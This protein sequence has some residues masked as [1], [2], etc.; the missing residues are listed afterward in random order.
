LP[1]EPRIED[2]PSNFGSPKG[3]VTS[4]G[5]PDEVVLANRPVDGERMPGY[6][7]AEGTVG[8]VDVGVW[9]GVDH[10]RQLRCWDHGGTDPPNRPGH[11][12]ARKEDRGSSPILGEDLRVEDAPGGPGRADVLGGQRGCQFADGSAVPGQGVGLVGDLGDDGDRVTLDV[13]AVVD[14]YGDIIVRAKYDGDYDKTNLPDELIMSNYFALR[15]GKIV[16][17]A[18]IRTQPSPY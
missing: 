2:G 1:A 7:R 16:S 4:F 17:L 13:R 3:L 8:S 12:I 15:D 18:V 6:V 11:R 9:A 5:G 14:H 10:R